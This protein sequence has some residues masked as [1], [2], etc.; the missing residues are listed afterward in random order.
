MK[1]HG[2]F[3]SVAVSC[4]HNQPVQLSQKWVLQYF[5]HSL[6]TQRGENT[7]NCVDSVVCFYCTR[8]QL[9]AVSSTIN[10]RFSI[11]SLCLY[12]GFRLPNKNN[13]SYPSSLISCSSCGETRYFNNKNTR[14]ARRGWQLP[15]SQT[16]D[17]HHD[18][19]HLARSTKENVS[20]TL[21]PCMCDCFSL[22]V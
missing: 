2:R 17:F 5:P 11:L 15:F 6:Y 8:E 9:T 4:L 18:F 3:L 7:A 21:I 14:F 12:C 16:Q 19:T 22:G 20:F 13:I 10:L 1:M